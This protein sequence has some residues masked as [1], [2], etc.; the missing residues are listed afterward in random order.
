MRALGQKIVL[1]IKRLISL[2]A[3]R[4]ALPARIPVKERVPD[5]LVIKLATERKHLSNVIK[6]VAYQ[7]ESDLVHLI[8]PHSPPRR[9]R[10]SDAHPDRAR[11]QGDHGGRRQGTPC[12]QSRR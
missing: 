8:E 1:K 10:R 5:G 9:R 3:K 6:M 12:P 11:C 7:A 2:E 4:D